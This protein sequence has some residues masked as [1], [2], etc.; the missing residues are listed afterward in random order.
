MLNVEGG[1]PFWSLH[2]D[3]V[4]VRSLSTDKRG[5]LLISSLE[6]PIY[7]KVL[8]ICWK[9][10][11]D[12]IKTLFLPQAK[13]D[14][15]ALMLRYLAWLMHDTPL[16]ISLWCAERCISRFGRLLAS[17]HV[18]PMWPYCR[19][20]INAQLIISIYWR[21]ERLVPLINPWCTGKL[22]WY[23]SMFWHV[24]QIAIPDKALCKLPLA[25]CWDHLTVVG[26]RTRKRVKIF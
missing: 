1:V 19:D 5:Q 16:F 24:Y 22:S 26:R 18:Y 12:S 21:E 6:T 14:S 9:L 2:F 20:T 13:S 7:C 25:V 11:A 4:V 3:W 8:L 10:L 15:T 17:R 23:R